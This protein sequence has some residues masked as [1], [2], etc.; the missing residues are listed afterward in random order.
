MHMKVAKSGRRI[1][2]QKSRCVARFNRLQGNAILRQIKIK[3]AYPHP[4]FRCRWESKKT[5]ISVSTKNN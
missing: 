2:Q 4:C 1:N 3:F 5:S